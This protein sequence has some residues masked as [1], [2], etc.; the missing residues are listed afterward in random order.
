MRHSFRTRASFA[1]AA[2]LV[3]F[4][5]EAQT[6]TVL[7]RFQGGKSGGNPFSGLTYV[8]GTLYG[9]T[10]N[11]GPTNEGNLFQVNA[12]TGAEKTLYSYLGRPTTGLTYYKGVLYGTSPAE[13]FNY[14]IA[15]KS[16]NVL[17]AFDQFVGSVSGIIYAN[18]ILYG[19]TKE[20]GLLAGGSIFEIDASTGQLTTLYYFPPGADGDY[21]LSGVVYQ[22]G[23]L[24]GTTEQGGSNGEGTVYS[25]DVAASKESVIYAFKNVPDG[26]EPVGGLV[27]AKGY[28][29]GTTVAGG[30]YNY[31]TVFR[32]DP[33]TKAEKILYSFRGKADGRSPQATLI[34]LAGAVYG[35]TSGVSNYGAPLD[36]G[37]VFKVNVNTG[38][39][40]TLHKF[41]GGNNGAMPY[42]GLVY[43]EGSFYGTTLLG[44]VSATGCDGGGCGTVFKITP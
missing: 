34:Y 18:G 30:K 9:T 42:G 14:V 33:T 23:V 25:F 3:S 6:F 5:A 27:F 31:G 15:T 7:H 28:F 39:E 37:S 17:C 32:L 16:F 10:Y 20:D 2:Y 13:A 19:T 24:F 4:A 12:M 26:G 41:A 43:A 36:D 21:P 35:T 44:G 38:A 40:T 11:G 22:N 1:V 29:Y 8:S